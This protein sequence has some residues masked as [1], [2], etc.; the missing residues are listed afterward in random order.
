MLDEALDKLEHARKPCITRSHSLAQ[1]QL[2][3]HITF[4][5]GLSSSSLIAHYSSLLSYGSYKP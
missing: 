2:N 4:S 3:S 5:F 1:A